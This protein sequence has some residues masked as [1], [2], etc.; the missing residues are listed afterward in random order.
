MRTSEP[1]CKTHQMLST[2]PKVVNLNDLVKQQNECKSNTKKDVGLLLD[3]DE[4]G[5]LPHLEVHTA[6][7]LALAVQPHTATATD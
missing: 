2:P 5:K 6:S 7:C 1:N 4:I 3:K